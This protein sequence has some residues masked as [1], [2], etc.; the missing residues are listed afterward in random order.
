VVD[1]PVGGPPNI[2]DVL[3]MISAAIP[4]KRKRIPKQHFD[5]P[6]AAAA[7]PAVTAA[8][9]KKGGRVKTK[10]VRPRGAPPSRVRTKAASRIGLAPPPP[11]KAMAPSPSV[12]SVPTPAP[13]PPFM[14]VDKVFDVESTIS[15]MDM[16]N[17]F[18]VDLV[19]GIDAFDGEDNV[20]DEEEEEGEGDEGVDDEV[21]EVDLASAGSS[22][23]KPRTSNYTKIEDAT[24]VRAWSRVGMDVCTG[25]DQGGKRY[26][27][28]IED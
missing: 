20:D 27:Q 1:V 6:A 19:A 13:P 26:W 25:V 5:A 7:P 9:D 12:P 23:T 14:N 15:Y 22:G 21:V 28:H 16:L 4:L 11:S 2:G 8:A 18:S 10:A 24:L 17:D 3:A